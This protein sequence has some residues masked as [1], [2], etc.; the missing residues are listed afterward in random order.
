MNLFANQ[1]FIYFNN[2]FAFIEIVQLELY[3]A[4][5]K[6][7]PF[8]IT[9]IFTTANIYPFKPNNRHAGTRCGMNS[10]LVIK[11]K[12]RRHSRRCGVFIVN[13]ELT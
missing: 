1:I 13:L 11:T 8:T 5:L 6:Y 4:S 3:V 10:A 2:F 7:L 12:E 9:Q